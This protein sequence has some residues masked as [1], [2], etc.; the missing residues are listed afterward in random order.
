MQNESDNEPLIS[1]IVIGITALACATALIAISVLGPA[2]LN[3]IHYRTSQSVV[4]QTQAF[5]IT[6]LILLVPL[7]IVGGTFA[8]L[9]KDSS[10]Y[11]LVLTPI[12]LIYSGLEYGIAQE[13]GNPAYSGNSEAFSGL[14]LA[15]TIGGLILLLGILPRFTSKDAPD[16][17]KKWLRV[18]VVV[19]AAF[20]LMFAFMWSSQLLQVI[21]TGNTA[22]GDYLTAP[23]GWWMVKFMDLGVTIPLGFIALLLLLSKPKRAYPLVLLFFG[24][25]ITLGTAVNASA[26]IEVINKD[27]TVT[28][29]T[30]AAGLVIFPVLAL[31]AYGGLFYLTKDKI[32]VK[33]RLQGR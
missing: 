15:L 11:F 13:W 30:G 26:L 24:F 21:T 1:P 27:P 22:A 29:G 12:M 19:M 3:I 14:F 20:L 10:K 9:K 18:Y 6:N 8:V 28:S 23:T 4:M 16:F 2:I 17:K 7:L 31:L 32:R 25:F 33:N 5:D